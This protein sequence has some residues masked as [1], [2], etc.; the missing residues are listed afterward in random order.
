[1]ETTSDSITPHLAKLK[2]FKDN[3]ERQVWL[4]YREYP[5]AND[6]NY[7]LHMCQ[8]WASLDR[9]A[10]IGYAAKE[11]RKTGEFNY[12]FYRAI[13]FLQNEEIA[14]KDLVHEKAFTDFDIEGGF[15]PIG[16][17]LSRMIVY[18]E[19]TEMRF[20]SRAIAARKVGIFV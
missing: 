14:I 4:V 15:D 7:M 8:E 5:N 6:Q 1:M 20:C 10:A 9:D 11:K 16:V 2:L 17:K 12:H 19:Q 18:P 3:G 13:L